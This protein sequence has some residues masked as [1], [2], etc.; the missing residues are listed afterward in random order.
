MEYLGAQE[1]GM[2]LLLYGIGDDTLA[3]LKKQYI[4]F[5]NATL[6]SMIQHLCEKTAIKMTTSQIFEYK[7]EGNGKQW[8]PTT[9]I[10]AYFTSHNKF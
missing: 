3:P 4:N 1:S 5:G 6:H 9:S 10:M 7:A 8:D 2:E